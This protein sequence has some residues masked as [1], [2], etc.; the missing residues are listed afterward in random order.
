M[1][2]CHL[3]AVRPSGEC[4]CVS[5]RRRATGQGYQPGCEAADADTCLVDDP[6]EF[7]E[8]LPV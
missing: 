7:L 5:G 3:E 4:F 2:T 6:N 8:G 1:R